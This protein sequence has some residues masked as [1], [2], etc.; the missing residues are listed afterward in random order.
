MPGPVLR[1]DIVDV[2]VFRRPPDF[3]PGVPPDVDADAGAAADVEF[4]QLHR[5]AA[6]AK[7]TWQPVMGHIEPGETAPAAALRELAEETGF[8]RTAVGETAGGT[9]A[10]PELHPNILGFWQLESVNT[11]FLAAE[12]CIMLCPGFA[13]E[14]PPNVNP[15]LDQAHDAFRWVKREAAGRAF[16]WPGQRTAIAQIVRDILPP[17]SPMAPLLRLDPSSLPP[18]SP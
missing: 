5:V 16:L 3:S 11:F 17:D 2:Y 6:P 8:G 18:L 4:L 9:P 12:D 15:V 7:G 10:P 1:T 14:V 13:I